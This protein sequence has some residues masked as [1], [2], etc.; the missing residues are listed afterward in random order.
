[1]KLIPLTVLFL[2]MSAGC[3]TPAADA[4]DGEGGGGAAAATTSTS[5]G[6]QST[7]TGSVTDVCTWK[8]CGGDPVGSWT[9]AS[10]CFD[11]SKS[12]GS[13]AGSYVGFRTYLTGTLDLHADGTALVDNTLVQETYV[14][15]PKT[16]WAPNATKCEDFVQGEGLTCMNT[17]TDCL[18]TTTSTQPNGASTDTFTVSNGHVVFADGTD[19]TFCADPSHLLLIHDTGEPTYFDA[20]E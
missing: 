17:A 8:A 6:A 1:M 2:T 13:C 20:V 14:Y 5:S 19:F 3:A 11:V 15:Y 7:S 12:P 9:Y 16:C 4:P 18:C 10:A